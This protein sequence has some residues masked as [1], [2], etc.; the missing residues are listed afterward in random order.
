MPAP[1]AK[2]A[3][4]TELSTARR[5][6]S[7]ESIAA[8]RAAIRAAVLAE[9]AAHGWMC[10][11]AYEPLATE[12]GSLELL[13]LLRQE[14][15]RVL[16][17][18]LR[19]DL[20]LDWTEWDGPRVAPGPVL[21]VDAIRAAEAVLVPALAVARDGTRLGRGGGSY[22]RALVRAAAAVPIVAVVFDD[23]LRAK[24]PRERWDVRV[25]GIVTPSGWQELAATS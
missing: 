22:D 25:T 5:E 16:V 15:V 11:A 8:A 3:L 14:G 19:P 17:P 24:L 1:S 13:E 9:R 2:A 4:R 20:D 7:A 18:L 23:E 12:P 6:R 10:V 21:G